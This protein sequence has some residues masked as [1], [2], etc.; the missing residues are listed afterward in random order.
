[1]R[2]TPYHAYSNSSVNKIAL[3]N[4]LQLMLCFP[5]SIRTQNEAGDSTE[6]LVSTAALIY[7]F[8]LVYVICELGGRLSYQFSDIDDIIGQFQWYLFPNDVQKLLP[9]VIM[10][11]KQKVALR[12]FGSA[13]CNRATFKKVFGNIHFQIF[14][15]FWL[16]NK[17]LFVFRY[18][19]DHIHTLWYWKVFEQ[20][21]RFYRNK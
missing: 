11:A 4:F 13:M 8:G 16:L 17:R 15:F 7:P 1:M 18:S 6:L 20:L 2:C 3:L 21:V 10:G 12:C 19:I 14:I 9:F 5:L